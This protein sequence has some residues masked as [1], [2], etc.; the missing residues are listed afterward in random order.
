MW[1]LRVVE[2]CRTYINIISHI[3]ITRLNESHLTV[4]SKFYVLTEYNGMDFNFKAS[5]YAMEGS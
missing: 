3:L 4:L 2:T 5:E 1:P